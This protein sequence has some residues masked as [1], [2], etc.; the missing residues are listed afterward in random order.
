MGLEHPARIGKT[1]SEPHVAA[2]VV[3]DRGAVTAEPGHVVSVEP[4][5]VRHGEM[6]SQ[7]AEPV[8]MR[9]LGSA[10]FPD[11]GHCLHL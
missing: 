10:V 8:E 3:R 2:R 4:D 5:A 9:G 1:R 7:D 6:R 11:A